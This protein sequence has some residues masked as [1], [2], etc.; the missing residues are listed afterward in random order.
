MHHGRSV[1]SPVLATVDASAISYYFKSSFI[2]SRFSHMVYLIDNHAPSPYHNPQSQVSTWNNPSPYG[3]LSHQ[4]PGQ[5]FYAQSG[6]IRQMS[7]VQSAFMNNE[8]AHMMQEMESEFG[9]DNEEVEDEMSVTT[10]SQSLSAGFNRLTIEERASSSSRSALI[11]GSS[12]GK[13]PRRIVIPGDYTEVD[14]N[15]YQSDFDS[16]NVKNNIVKN[17][18]NRRISVCGECFVWS[19]VFPKQTFPPLV[20]QAMSQS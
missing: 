19:F 6:D 14:D 3:S 16:H 17:S 9:E 4:S 18:F 10:R 13:S 5:Y 2:T 8:M 15:F 20:V 7:A 1:T 11:H 12:A